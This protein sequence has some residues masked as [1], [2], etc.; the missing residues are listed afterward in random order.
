MK[1]VLFYSSIFYLLKFYRVIYF[2]RFDLSILFFSYN[3]LA[4]VFSLLKENPNFSEASEKEFFLSTCPGVAKRRL[5]F[6]KSL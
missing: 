1:N 2:N 5:R 6:G 4:N 3:I